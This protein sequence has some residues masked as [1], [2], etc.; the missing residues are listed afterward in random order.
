MI[1]RCTAL[2]LLASAAAAGPGVAPFG[3]GSFGRHEPIEITA[4]ELELQDTGGPRRLA[5]RRNVQVRQGPLSLSARLLEATYP[6]GERQPDQLWARGEVEIREG[7]RRALC[8]EAHY[9]RP[10]QR[11]VCRGE[12]A[13]LWD[14]EDRLSGGEVWFDLAQRSVRVEQGAELQIQRDLLE[15]AGDDA[16]STDASR[17]I[18]ERMREAGPL[19]VRAAR[20]EARD[21]AGARHISFD[22]GVVVRQDDLE[23]TS[24]RLEVAYPQHATRPD[25]L[26]A[27]DRVVIREGRRE[28]RCAQAEYRPAERRIAC[29]GGAQLRDAD[30]VFE[31]DRIQFDFDARRVDAVGRA[32]LRVEP[33]A[34]DE[35]G[36]R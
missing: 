24:E 14:A 27:R 6:D 3:L 18:L 10:A 9:D 11:I 2:V 29:E 25:R 21:D 26:I 13:E 17:E 34:R 4:D 36:P 8:R 1:G 30:D 20:L 28:A 15:L 12:P 22:G 16:G 31:G 33:R 7:T 19:A 5:F 35:Q 23:L 32:R